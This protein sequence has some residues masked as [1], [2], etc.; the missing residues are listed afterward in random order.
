VQRVP[1]HFDRLRAAIA[2][3]MDRVFLVDGEKDVETLEAAGYV[4]T[5]TPL[6][7]MGHWRPEWAAYFYGA[8]RVTIIADKDPDGKGA[9][10]AW[11]VADSLQIIGILIEVKQVPVG[12]DITEFFEGAAQ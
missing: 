1:Y 9:K 3:G 2:A 6:G 10:D 7:N 5:T 4:A 11:R 8:K 12:K